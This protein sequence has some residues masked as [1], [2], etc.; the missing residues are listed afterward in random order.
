MRPPFHHP[1]HPRMRSHRHRR[2]RECGER[3][4]LH[5]FKHRLHWRLFFWFGASIVVTFVVVGAVA[6]RIRGDWERVVDGAQ[7]FTASRFAAVWD[8]PAERRALTAE[9]ARDLGLGVSVVDAT[10]KPLD[11]AGDCDGDEHPLPVV[12]DGRRLGEVRLCIRWGQPA[13]LVGGFVFAALMLWGAAGMISRRL[14][15]PLGEVARVAGEIGAG[16][17]SSRVRF[18]RRAPG[19]LGE[20]GLAINDMAERIEKQMDDQRSL[21]AAVSHELRTPLGHMRVIAELARA[22]DVDRLAE[23]E[24]EITEVDTMV[25]QLLASSRIEFDTIDRRALDAVDVSLR[26]LERAD[27]DASLLDI[28]IEDRQVQ[29]DAMLLSRALGNLIENAQRHADKIVAIRLRERADR[30]EFAVVDRGPGFDPAELPRVFESFQRGAR[31]GRAS[32]GSLGLGLALVRRIAEAHDGRAW[33]RN[34]DG[35]A[36]VGFEISR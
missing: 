33:A 23:L 15:R 24:R 16:K 32:A 34:V 29:G 14:V 27:I 26:A 8:R 3:G 25:D 6:H 11:S 18:H 36:E 28:D 12:R 35:G 1:E 30:V 7:V 17:L 4:R 10:G 5:R 22:G 13:Y 9:L 20:L 2:D 31:A 21:L 19:E